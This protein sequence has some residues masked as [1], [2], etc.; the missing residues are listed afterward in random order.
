[1]KHKKQI[2]HVK[3]TKMFIKFQFSIQK[4]SI[5]K[6]FKNFIFNLISHFQNIFE[7]QINLIKFFFDVFK[8]INNLSNQISQKLIQQMSQKMFFRNKN[9]YSNLFRKKCR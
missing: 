9:F 6:N 7:F 1:M 3:K 8:F 4:I 2:T 5:S